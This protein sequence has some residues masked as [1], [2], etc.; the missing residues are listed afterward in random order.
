MTS[1]GNP[2]YKG[3]TQ[4]DAGS[5]YELYKGIQVVDCLFFQATETLLNTRQPRRVL[6]SKNM[7]V[8]E[9]ISHNLKP[10]FVK[11]WRLNDNS[12]QY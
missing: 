7:H 11:V 3:G 12:H 1:L 5:P 10:R 9:R 4:G 2:Q 6:Y 8:K